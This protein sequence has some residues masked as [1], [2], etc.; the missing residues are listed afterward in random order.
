MRGIITVV[1]RFDCRRSQKS[2]GILIRIN[3]L[4][5]VREIILIMFEL[6]ASLLFVTCL[7]IAQADHHLIAAGCDTNKTCLQF[8]SCSITNSPST[9]NLATI[10]TTGDDTVEFQLQYDNVNAGWIAIGLS[11]TQSMPNSYIF[12]CV[13]PDS[14][15]VDVQERFATATA[16]PP[17]EES[18]LTTVSTANEGSLFNCT[19]TSPVTRTPMLNDINGYHVLLAWGQYSGNNIQQHAGSGRCVTGNRMIVTD[20]PGAQP[21]AA[22]TDTPTDTPSRCTGDNTCI[23]F[24]DCSI[25]TL[26]NST[27]IASYTT[28]SDNSVRFNLEYTTDNLTDWI[29]IGLSTS[30]SMLDAYIFLCHRDGDAGVTIQ[31][32]YAIIRGYPRVTTPSLLTPV[33]YLNSRP[34]LNCTFTSPVTRLPNLNDIDGYHVLLARGRFDGDI[35]YHGSDRCFTG[36]RIRITEAVGDSG[37][38]VIPTTRVIF[39]MVALLFASYLYV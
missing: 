36:E 16:R 25:T 35:Q 28:L 13:R 6:I 32:R 39:C 33:A 20:A 7:G 31:E 23:S 4:G 10:Y 5:N 37:S 9:P 11:T 26:S 24:S 12:M 21:T 2:L 14:S 17:L 34:V 3:K 27:D 18:F 29:A 30:P 15:S 22:P 19:F 1:L 38:I 8:G